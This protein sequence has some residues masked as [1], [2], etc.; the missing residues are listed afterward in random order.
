MK[1]EKA[2]GEVKKHVEST[3]KG[4]E[5]KMPEIKLRK[6]IESVQLDLNNLLL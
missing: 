1:D 3:P 4:K 5:Y 2:E 6:I